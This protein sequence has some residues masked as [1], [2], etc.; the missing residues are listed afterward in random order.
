[1]ETKENVTEFMYKVHC[2]LWL[3]LI[4]VKPRLFLAFLLSCGRHSGRLI[5]NQPSTPFLPSPWLPIYWGCSHAHILSNY[6][7]QMNVD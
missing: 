5:Q 1:M 4:L 3:R 6:P 7:Q 2:G